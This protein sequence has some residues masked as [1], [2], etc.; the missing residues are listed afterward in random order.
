M[1]WW[2]RA[3]PIGAAT[4]RACLA[5]L[6]VD[7]AKGASGL[8]PMLICAALN[9]CRSRGWHE[10]VASIHTENLPARS[11]YAKMGFADLFVPISDGLASVRMDLRQAARANNYQRKSSGPS[12]L[13]GP[14]PIGSKHAL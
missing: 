10:V 6:A 5:Y 11:L 1:L 14:D 7:S 9:E 12:A 4:P 2:A 13:P 3:R 8:A